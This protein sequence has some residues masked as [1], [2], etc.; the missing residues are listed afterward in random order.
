M[1]SGT[2][3][4]RLDGSLLARGGF[5]SGEAPQSCGGRGRGVA[6]A[7][8]SCRQQAGEK[9]LKAFLA[10][11]SQPFAGRMIWWPFGLRHAT[12]FLFRGAN[13]CWEQKG[14]FL[15]LSCAEI[16]D[17]AQKV[18]KYSR[19]RPGRAPARPFLHSKS[20]ISAQNGRFCTFAAHSCT[21][22]AGHRVAGSRRTR[23]E[24]S[25]GP[26]PPLRP[27]A[28]SVRWRT[29]LAREYRV[30]RSTFRMTPLPAPGEGTGGAVQHSVIYVQNDSPPRAGEGKGVG[31]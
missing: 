13:R 15:H 3:H 25:G 24:L 27:R 20:P 19:N 12:A 29:V 7:S 6:L 10:W 28:P 4:G 11:H 14:S 18:Q 21:T 17:P 22:L 26:T 9:A 2:A 5:C 30:A 23:A 31:S 8:G 16:A 1:G